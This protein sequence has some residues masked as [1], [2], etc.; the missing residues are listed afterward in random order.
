MGV[1]KCSKCVLKYPEHSLLIWKGKNQRMRLL[2]LSF[3]PPDVRCT[4]WVAAWLC[5][6]SLISST[7]I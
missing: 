1:S 3:L 5:T 7:F 2:S 4:A 6:G